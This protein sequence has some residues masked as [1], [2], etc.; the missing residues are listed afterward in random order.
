[1]ERRASLLIP[2][3]QVRILGGLLALG[4]GSREAPQSRLRG[5]GLLNKQPDGV[6]RLAN[7]RERHVP[8]LKARP[9]EPLDGGPLGVA[10]FV[11]DDEQGHLERILEVHR[12]KAPCVHGRPG[13]RE[14]MRPMA[15]RRVRS[16]SASRDRCCPRRPGTGWRVPRGPTGGAGRER[17]DYGPH[18]QRWPAMIRL[19]DRPAPGAGCA[20]RSSAASGCATCC[21]EHPSSR[22]SEGAGSQP[23]RRPPSTP[24]GRASGGRS[25]S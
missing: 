8:A 15:Q 18:R 9:P 4:R 12:P 5:I 16:A 7:L 11:L 2:R 17:H 22:C 25:R 21:P 1:M 10:G 14:R 19:T 3:S 6:E 13:V 20:S 24:I 23:S